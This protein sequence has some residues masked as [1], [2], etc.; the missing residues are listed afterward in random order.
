MKKISLN[1]LKAHCSEDKIHIHFENVLVSDDGI[2]ALLDFEY[3][4]IAPL[5]FEL[6]KIINF[7]LSP[8]K[9]VETELENQYSVTDLT[10]VI[11][12]VKKYYSE[13]FNVDSLI[14]RQRI[15]LIPDVLWG[16][17]WAHILKTSQDGREKTRRTLRQIEARN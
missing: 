14:E 4:D 16:F 3:A 15:Y 9:F 10:Q 7:C 8:Q 6:T 2:Q 17:K 13:L 5:D 12:W 11:G 1:E